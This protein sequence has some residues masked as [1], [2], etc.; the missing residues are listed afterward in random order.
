MSTKFKEESE[1]ETSKE[2]RKR[3][4]VRLSIKDKCRLVQDV[5]KGMLKRDAAKKYNID[6]AAV[7]YILQKKD[8]YLNA[9]GNNCL[10]KRTRLTKGQHHV[11]EMALVAWI[12]QQ[13]S[14]GITVNGPMIRE[15]ASMLNEQ[16]IKV[17]RSEKDQSLE[18]SKPEKKFTASDGWLTKFK[19]RHGMREVRLASADTESADKAGFEIRQFLV[20]NGYS[21]DN[22]YNADETGILHK[23][24]PVKTLAF[25]EEKCPTGFKDSKERV[26]IM[27]CANA[28][29]SHK[30]PLLIIGNSVKPRCFKTVK[31]EF[32]V[33]YACQSNSWMTG[34]IFFEWYKTVFINSVKARKPDENEKFL[35]ILDNAPCHPLEEELNK[36]DRQFRVL[37]LPVNVTSLIQPMNQGITGSMKR[38]Y[39]QIFLRRMLFDDKSGNIVN[40][41]K[42][43]TLVDTAFALASAWNNVPEII[44]TKC[45]KKLLEDQVP[46]VEEPDPIATDVTGLLNSVTFSEIHS[47]KDVEAWFQ[48]EENLEICR[49]PTFEEIME[50]AFYAENVKS[51]FDDHQS[52]M[53]DAK[54]RATGPLGE[55]STSNPKEPYKHFLHFREWFEENGQCSSDDIEKLNHMQDFVEQKL[56]N[57]MTT[58]SGL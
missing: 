12:K 45:W 23:S 56:F 58:A 18:L 6:Q 29:G 28:T 41:V 36:I 17:E 13:R 2:N 48:E 52:A 31:V 54:S 49:T 16:L 42:S 5:E 44:I 8:E 4:Y 47:N 32:P 50:N 15:K 35:L 33:N 51:E 27:N 22:V 37:Y 3:K 24:L 1:G 53:D 11:M 46:V 43:W 38:N 30:I 20:E 10:E 39:K 40:F 7:T 19:A 9:N 14:R 26:T 25:A 57:F 21:L 34:K 55:K